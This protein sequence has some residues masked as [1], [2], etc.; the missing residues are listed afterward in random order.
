MPKSEV[1]AVL[2]AL[3]AAFASAIGNVARQRSAHEVTEERCRLPRVVFHVVAQSRLAARSGG[4]G[5][6][7]RPTGRGAEPRFGDPGDRAAGDGIAVR[8]AALRPDER[9]SG[10]PVGLVLGG[11]IGHCA[12]RRRDRRQSGGRIFAGAAAHVAGGCRHRGAVGWSVSARGAALAGWGD[13]GGAAGC[14]VRCVAGAVRGVGERRC[15]RGQGRHR[16]GAGHSRALCLHRRRGRRDGV[17]AVGIS[18]WAAQC[19]HADDDGGQADGRHAAGC[20][21]ARR[22]G[23]VRATRRCSSSASRSQ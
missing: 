6:Q 1:A 7:L 10:D 16:G 18:R 22:N 11:D 23:A 5:R 14:G 9:G 2:L 13:R 3:A 4:G 17:P 15:R 20:F 21:C 12:G 8:S 19:L